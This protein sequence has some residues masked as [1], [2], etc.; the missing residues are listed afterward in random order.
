MTTVRSQEGSAGSSDD[1]L[2]SFTAF[3]L[4]TVDRTFQIAWRT[5]SNNQALAEDATQDAY[6]AMFKRWNERSGEP[7]ESNRRYVVGIAVNKVVDWYRRKPHLTELDEQYDCGA[8]ETGFTEVLDELTILQDVRGLIFTQPPRRRAVAVLFFLEQY[9]YAEI[10]KTLG[11][12]ES[13]VR[14]HVERLRKQLRPYI[15]MINTNLESE[16]T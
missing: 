10:A 4:D 1:R 8:E 6:L 3:Y 7:T 13:T 2:T 16:R 14:T 12:T 11:I 9:N 15:Q 5:T